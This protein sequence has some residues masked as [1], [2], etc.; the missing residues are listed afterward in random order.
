MRGV[1]HLHPALQKTVEKLVA[2]CKAEGLNILITETFRTV[3]EQDA[4]YAQGRTKPGSIVTNAKGSSYSSMHQWHCAFD[5]CKNVK[6]AEYSDTAFFNKVGA[7]GKSLG[8]FWGGDFKSITDKP[9][10]QMPE[11]SPDGTTAWLKKQYGTPDKFKETWKVEE[12]EVTYDD[13]KKFMKQYESD[14]AKEPP[15]DWAKDSWKEAC[16][17]DTLTGQKLF[18]GTNPQGFATREQLATLFKRLG[19]TKK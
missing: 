13:F 11:F 18:D 16:D 19:L 2:H 4:L 6:G 17:H 12:D 8:L 9:H 14:K 1:E 15:Q 3:A 10:F 5:F 7:I